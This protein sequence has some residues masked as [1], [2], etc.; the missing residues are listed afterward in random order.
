MHKLI[1]IALTLAIASS[2]FL[3]T[4][5]E[6]DVTLDL[7]GSRFDSIGFSNCGSQ[8]NKYQVSSVDA[9]I[10]GDNYS[11]NISGN[12]DVSLYSASISVQ[13]SNGNSVYSNSINLED[14][15]NISF[16]FSTG[17]HGPLIST[18]TIYALGGAS[19]F[20]RNTVSVACVTF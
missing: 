16:S 4:G 15:Y 7:I 6:S 3:R 9:E 14:T 5:K 20:G 11:Y 18:V 17:A 10:D 12:G 1:F 8:E 2:Q 19:P 13:D